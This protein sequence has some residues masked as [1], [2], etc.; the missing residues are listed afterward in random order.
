MAE[1]I[2]NLLNLN[3]E[4]Q[5]SFQSIS[6]GHEYHYLTAE[7][8]TPDHLKGA[9][10]I[11]GNVHP[12]LVKKASG[13]RWLQTES[14]GYDQYME[15]GLLPTDCRLT[16]ASGAYGTS[17][18]EHMLAMLL[19]QMKNLHGYRH[20]QLRSQWQ[21][22]GEAKTLVDANVLIVGT[23]DLGT[24][25]A[26]RVKALGAHTMGVRRDV[27]KP[28]DGIDT[29]HSMDEMDDLL[30]RADVVALMLPASEET[31][32]LMDRRRLKLM[33]PDA[34]LLNAGR[35]S[36]VNTNDLAD[37]LATGHLWGAALDVTEP[38][39]LP[40]DHPLW[41]QPRVTI[42]PHSSGGDHLTLTLKRVNKIAEE[43]LKHY[44]AGE[45]LINR[46]K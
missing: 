6:E 13:L 23:G 14:A 37:V 7:I 18:S 11:L 44:I 21:D 28:A 20:Q 32:N 25:L 35:G 33:K 15:P 5:A 10:V 12:D 40:N 45:D 39:P 30:P 4:E 22:L 43:N 3:D 46:R 2:L 8:L 27:D 24:S 41:H 29:M 34:I 9:T 19:G 38:E 42:T 36:A 26:Q 17:V 31:D 16:N 1:R